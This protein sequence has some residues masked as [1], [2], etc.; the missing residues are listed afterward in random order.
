MI[1]WELVFGV[2]NA[3]G[4]LATFFAFLLLF[5]KDKDKQTQIDQLTHVANELA[6]MKAIENQKLNLSIK[7]ELRLGKSHYNGT[8][9][10]MDMTIEN[11]GERAILTE[12]SLISDDIILHNEH[13]PFTLQKGDSRKIFSRIKSDK[14]IKDSEYQIKIHYHDKI[15]NYYI[16]VLNGKGLKNILTEAELQPVN[17]LD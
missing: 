1:D 16:S 13:L 11:I 14:H 8:D 10:E 4:S 17:R 15:G 9:G 3:L 2:I 7:P 5:K 12:F 6:Q